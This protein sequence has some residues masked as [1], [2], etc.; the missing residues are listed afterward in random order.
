MRCL[1]PTRETQTGFAAEI[2]SQTIAFTHKIGRISERVDPGLRDLEDPRIKKED[3]TDQGAV[4]FRMPKRGLEPP[5]PCE[6]H[7]LKVARLP[8]PPPGHLSEATIAFDLRVSSGIIISD[9]PRRVSRLADGISDL[10][11]NGSKS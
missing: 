4:F 5:L 8:I 1:E 10:A 2:G 3:G 6:N 9:D 11:S 7:H